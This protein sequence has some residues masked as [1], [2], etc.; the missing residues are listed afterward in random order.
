MFGIIICPVVFYIPKFFE[1]KT[2]Y[3]PYPIRAVVDCAFIMEPA[4]DLR[5]GS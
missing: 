2:V 3:S 5:G 1:L 4:D